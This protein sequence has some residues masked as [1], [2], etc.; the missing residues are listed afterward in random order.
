MSGTRRRTRA[1][2]LAA[3]LLALSAPACGRGH[4][5]P[6]GGANTSPAKVKLQRLVDI[7]PVQQRSIVYHVET[8]GVLE[9]EG[10][11]D[12]A[13]GVSGLVDEVLFREGDEVTPG[14]VLV[15]IDQARYEAEEAA[16]RASLERAQA[17][18]ELANDLHNR[19]ERL[20][21]GASDEERVKS[22]GA[23]RVAD[24]ELRA[25]QA[26]LIRARH[27]LE[28]SRVRAPY[29]GRI[30]KRMVAKGTYLEDKTVIA[31]I[32]D[33]S[34]IRLV[35]YVPETAAPTVRK[36]LNE[37]AQRLPLLKAGLPLAGV[38]PGQAP[39]AGALGMHLAH[40]D[41]VPS[42]SDPEFELLALP[43]QKFVGRIFY[44]S[45]VGA[46]DT[47]MFEAKAEVLGWEAP[48][49]TV[50]AWASRAPWVGL[51]AGGGLGLRGAW[52]GLGA[53]P[54]RAALVP[55]R[56]GLELRPGFTAKIR[57]PMRSSHTAVVIPEEAGKWEAARA[58]EHGFIAFVPVP[59]RDERGR[60]LKD[61]DGQVQWVAERRTLELG[62]R[63]PGWVEVRAG[64]APG[65]WVVRRGADTLENG[66]PLQIAEEQLR[67]MLAE[68]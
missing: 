14:T 46:P 53:A 66:T 42:G 12:I 56:P 43:G 3:A 61:R 8:V 10:Q 6:T 7:T 13:A 60:V 23:V 62:Y 20:G 18:L 35:G 22:R 31:T 38:G 15:K 1:G 17:T 45:T 51:A 26:M 16:A 33:L 44:M 49:P 50:P 59:E 36:A 4:G 47:H 54:P 21:R 55:E 37:Q 48:R 65:E 9:A 32:A 57:F 25:A 34:K 40:K 2:L 27:N 39:W 11:T 68:R 67:E 58:S 30:N 64:L 19:N 28:R 5:A 29:A 63:A 52:G 41:Y 24:A